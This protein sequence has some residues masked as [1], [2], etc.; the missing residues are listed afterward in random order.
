MG[1]GPVTMWIGL[2]KNL[3][4][5]YTHIPVDH[6]NRRKAGRKEN[7]DLKTEVKT[8]LQSILKENWIFFIFFILNYCFFSVF[9]LFWCADVK[10]NF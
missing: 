2:K 5:G 4:L 8:C 3:E 6:V 10:N 7:E 1:S 9:V